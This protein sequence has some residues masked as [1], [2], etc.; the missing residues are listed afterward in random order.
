MNVFSNMR[1]RRLFQKTGVRQKGEII[2]YRE[3]ENHI[4]RDY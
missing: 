4:L 1:E 2:K 3:G